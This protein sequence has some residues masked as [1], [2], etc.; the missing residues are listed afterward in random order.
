MGVTDHHVVLSLGRTALIV[1]QSDQDREPELG[2]EI[3]VTFKDGKGMV[4]PGKGRD[5]GA[6]R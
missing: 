4:Q 6:E 5:Q 1:E 3:S 2:E